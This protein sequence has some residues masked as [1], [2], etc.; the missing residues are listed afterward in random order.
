MA[1]TYHKYSRG[2]YLGFTGLCDEVHE[3]L[4]VGKACASVLVWCVGRYNLVASGAV[5]VTCGSCDLLLLPPRGSRDVSQPR[6]HQATRISKRRFDLGCFRRT[7]HVLPCLSNCVPPLRESCAWLHP[8]AAPLRNGPQH[9][10]RSSAQRRLAFAYTLN[11]FT[12]APRSECNAPGLGL[13]K[14]FR[15]KLPT[16]TW[17]PASSSFSSSTHGTMHAPACLAMRLC[18][19]CRPAAV[20]RKQDGGRMSGRRREDKGGGREQSKASAKIH[21]FCSVPEDAAAGSAGTGAAPLP[22]CCISSALMPALA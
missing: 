1:R 16:E 10:S 13:L 21:T 17:F 5:A 6:F 20:E 19:P 9:H 12:V 3:P 7:R 14:H 2:E 11:L 15:S 4:T 18:L 22:L 8:S